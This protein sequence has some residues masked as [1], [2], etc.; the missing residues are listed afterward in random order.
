VTADAQLQ[1]AEVELVDISVDD[2]QL[3]AGEAP[4]G[5]GEGQLPATIVDRYLAAEADRIAARA[6]TAGTRRQYASIYRSF[7]TWLAA[8]LGRPPLVGDLDA[9]VI[10]AYG[11]YLTASGGRGGA[12]AAG[13]RPRVRVDDPGARLGARPERPGRRRPRTT[14]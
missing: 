9:D 12:P 10:A 8:Q 2:V 13:D 7:A 4:T 14:P 6:S 3:V 11:R 5:V 1:L